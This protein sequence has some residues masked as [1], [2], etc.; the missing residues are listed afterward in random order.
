M[1]EGVERVV[2]Q[3]R[4]KELLRY[5]LIS[6]KLIGG[7]VLRLVKKLDTNHANHGR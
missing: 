5:D 1:T 2:T 4:L 7:V 6:G 3:R